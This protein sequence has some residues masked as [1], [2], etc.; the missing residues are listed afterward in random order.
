METLSRQVR[1]EQP[2]LPSLFLDAKLSESFYEL[3]GLSVNLPQPSVSKDATAV[4]PKEERKSLLR[5]LWEAWKGEADFIA[6][7]KAIWRVF[8]G[9]KEEAKA[10]SPEPPPVIPKENNRPFRTVYPPG[11]EIIHLAKLM[12]YIGTVVLPQMDGKIREGKLRRMRKAAQEVEAF[13]ASAAVY[14]SGLVI[15]AD[16]CPVEKERGS[17]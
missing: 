14:R 4:E 7:L 9:K 12:G 10:A 6:K 11:A 3:I 5:R 17:V 13:L 16:Y 2:N 15:I 8:F 1:L